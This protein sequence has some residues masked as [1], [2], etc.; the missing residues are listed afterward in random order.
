MPSLNIVCQ[1]EIMGENTVTALKLISK[2]LEDNGELTT[3]EVYNKLLD[4]GVRYLPTYRQ[5]ASLLT[6]HPSKFLLVRTGEG[7]WRQQKIKW[8]RNNNE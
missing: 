1:G 3:R 5:V 8:W 6:H 7:S 4:T 2:I